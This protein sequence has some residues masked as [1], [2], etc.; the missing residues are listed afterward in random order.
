M[1]FTSSAWGDGPV[2]SRVKEMGDINCSGPREGPWPS[3]LEPT[4]AVRE[5]REWLASAS[6]QGDESDTENG[7]AA[8]SRDQTLGRARAAD[9]EWLDDAGVPANTRCEGA[10]T[11]L[12]TEGKPGEAT[13]LGLGPPGAAT[14]GRLSATG[15]TTEWQDD[16]GVSDQGGPAVQTSTSTSAPAWVN[17]FAN[18]TI[19]LVDASLGSRRWACQPQNP[20]PNLCRWSESCAGCWP[21]MATTCC[22]S[23]ARTSCLEMLD[24]CE[25]CL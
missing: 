13:A 21:M 23:C 9:T 1:N 2:V 5:A 22:L 10:A 17:A 20:P 15:V 7:S 6:D 24:V 8:A 19:E 25:C 11:A 3:F 4:C 14:G 18:V 12:T 16:V